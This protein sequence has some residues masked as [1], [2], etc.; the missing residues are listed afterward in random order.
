LDQ[1]SGHGA[2]SAAYREYVRS[3]RCEF[4][5]A[6]GGYVG[7]RC[8]WFSDRLECYLAAGRPVI[9]RAT[10][11]GDFLPTGKAFTI[12]DEAVEAI[13][14]VRAD[15]PLHSAAARQIA[16]QHFDSDKILR[17]LLAEAG[18]A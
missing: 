9:L 14:A 6:K 5:C 16:L 18:L 7:T 12:M 15:Y 11:F 8:G 10:G 2:Y 17:R 13:R 1:A 4:T 3:P